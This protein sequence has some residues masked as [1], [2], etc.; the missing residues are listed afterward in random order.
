MSSPIRLMHC[1]LNWTSEGVAAPHD[2]AF[3]DPEEY[4]NWHVKFGTN[5]MYC[6]AIIHCG[7]AFYP[8][9]LGPTAPG[10]GRD[11]FPQLYELA[12]TA[13][14]PTWS[15]MCVGADLMVGRT[16]RGWLVPEARELCFE[17]LGPESGWTDLL[18]ERIREFLG[19]YPVDWM[20]FDFLV[21]GGLKPNEFQIRPAPFVAEP[22][23][24][25]IG[26]PMP[27][28]AEDITPEEN[29]RY[30]REVLA[31]QFY[32]I[33]NAVKETSPTTKI[34][35]NVPYWEANEAL[36]N[37]HPMMRESDGL[38]AEC[39]KSEIVD[40]LLEV[41]Q[42]HQ[43]VMCTILGRSGDHCDPNAWQHW[44][45]KGCDFFG[46]AWGTPPDFRPQ[47]QYKEGLEIVREAFRQIERDNVNDASH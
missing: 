35:F 18:C 16:R 38:F 23:E 31:E 12:T 15:Y 11:L 43:R 20:L 28:R 33:R 19:L 32:S 6:Q 4:F 24:S 2:W 30:K 22:F 17:F 42:P 21:Y 44:Y 39:S 27:D 36:W 25:I 3:I 5:V 10:Q 14:F 8:T 13:G 34:M 37:D 29:L 9:E 1:D 47:P 40:W 26:R 7:A 45:K 41:R 46:Y